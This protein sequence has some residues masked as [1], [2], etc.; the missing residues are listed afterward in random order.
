MALFLWVADGC[1]SA[2]PEQFTGRFFEALL[3]CPNGPL[4]CDS[5]GLR[6]SSNLAMISDDGKELTV[7][8]KPR[9]SDPSELDSLIGRI[10]GIFGSMGAE[11]SHSEVFPPWLEPEDSRLV[12]QAVSAYRKVYGKEP[13][14]ACTHGGLESSTI[15]SKHPGMSAVSVG[16]TIIGAHTPGERMSLESLCMTKRFV[17]ELVRGIHSFGDGD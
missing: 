6:T 7:V 15:K 10:E 8:A 12:G 9:S 5:R 14:V 11:P 17:F 4:E 3:S 1:A 13:R 16:P 2:W